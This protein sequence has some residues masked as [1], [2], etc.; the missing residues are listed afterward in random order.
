MKKNIPVITIDGPGG[1]GKSTLC[2]RMAE[3]LKWNLLDSGAIYRTLAYV[4]IH[5]KINIKSEDNLVCIAKKLD[6]SFLIKNK[7]IKVFLSGI[8]ITNNIR[9]E[10]ISSMAS[11]IAIFPQVRKIILKYQRKFLQKPG[12]IAE[13]RDMGTIVFANAPVKIFLDARLEKRVERRFF[14]LKK[15]GIKNININ[16]ILDKIKERDNRD[17][18]RLIAPLLPANDAYI[19]DATQMTIEQLIS[20]SLKYVCQKLHLKNMYF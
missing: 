19:L 11:K 2:K 18:S 14:Q 8:D 17:Y 3:N 5:E 12:L 13:G 7:K 16:Y 15:L 1:S 9:T 6:V 20:K 10:E 4:V